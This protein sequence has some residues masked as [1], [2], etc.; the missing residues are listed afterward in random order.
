MEKST[1]LLPPQKRRLTQK[2]K[3]VNHNKSPETIVTPKL[4]KMTELTNQINQVL[5]Q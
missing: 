4:I 5:F 1:H 3:H 2:I